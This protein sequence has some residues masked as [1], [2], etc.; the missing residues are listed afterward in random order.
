MRN[1]NYMRSG[2]RSRPAMS[3]TR[4]SRGGGGVCR[5][6]TPYESPHNIAVKSLPKTFTYRLCARAQKNIF[7]EF[8]FTHVLCV[9][10]VHFI[11]IIPLFN[12]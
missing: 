2:V 12:F 7:G 1:C 8:R 3:P 5:Q 11:P 4:G 6:Y 10:N 9:Q